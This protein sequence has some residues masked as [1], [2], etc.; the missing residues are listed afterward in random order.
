MSGKRSRSFKCAIH[1]R[2]GEV[3]SE[4]D[5]HI[6]YKEPPLFQKMV[7]LIAEEFLTEG[8]DRK[9]YADHYTCCP[10]PVFILFITFLELIRLALLAAHLAN[11]LLNYNQMEFGIVRLLAI[12][13]VAS[14]DV[15][16]AIYNRYA[17]ELAGAGS[18]YPVS[19][20]A[21][22]TGALAGL[23]IGLLVLKNFE[24][25]LREQLMWWIALGVY[26]ACTIFAVIYN[27]TSPSYN[28]VT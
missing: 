9:Y 22:L 7:H 27:V 3:T 24:Q 12:F 2:D 16:F 26:V 28:Y 19:Y 10:P 11:V 20:V 25:K 15:G 6:L 4:N 23:T 17:G 1:S 8:R 18:G 5:F 21:H 13:V 14:A